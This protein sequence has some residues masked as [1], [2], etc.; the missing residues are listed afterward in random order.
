M[1][2]TEDTPTDEQQTNWIKDE[3]L[4]YKVVEVWK[5]RLVWG[6]GMERKGNLSHVS[7]PVSQCLS[8]LIALYMSVQD[9]SIE[10]YTCTSYLMI[11][12][13]TLPQVLEEAGVTTVHQVHKSS[14][15]I[16]LVA[17]ALFPQ[18]SSPTLL[19]SLF[20]TTP[21]HVPSEAPLVPPNPETS[22]HTIQISPL[23]HRGHTH[24]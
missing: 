19:P 6:G 15:V 11:M 7:P 4:G 9:T 22:H 8:T 13:H 24:R 20:P 3:S 14:S 18:A 1:I 10:T 2:V 5:G 12:G 21:F 23:S 17:S 16:V